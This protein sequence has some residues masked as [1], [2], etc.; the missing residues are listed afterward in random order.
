[1]MTNLP[2]SPNISIILNKETEVNSNKLIQIGQNKFILKNL[3]NE[4]S[5]QFCI[6]PSIKLPLEHKRRYQQ[7][8]DNQELPKIKHIR[9]QS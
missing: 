7:K 5:P 9:N 4:R 1:M 8:P 2:N 3:D 6:S